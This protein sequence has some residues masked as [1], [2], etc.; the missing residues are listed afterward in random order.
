MSDICQQPVVQVSLSVD[1]LHVDHDLMVSKCFFF[2]FHILIVIPM[3][4]VLSVKP[5]DV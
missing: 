2:F 4:S 1:Q 5:L 3:S